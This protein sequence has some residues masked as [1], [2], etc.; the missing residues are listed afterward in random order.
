MS[1]HTIDGNTY[2]PKYTKDGNM[3]IYGKTFYEKLKKPSF[4]LSE[5]EIK[6][7]KLEKDTD[8][9]PKI[10]TKAMDFMKTVMKRRNELGMKQSDLARECK[11][12]PDIIRDI[13]K[14]TLKPD[15]HLH[16]KLRKVLR[17]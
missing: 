13:E 1:E 7:R 10:D 4:A 9:G 6:N 17:M 14:G 12:K 5:E 11:V 16:Q 2:M 8:C 3:I 15:N